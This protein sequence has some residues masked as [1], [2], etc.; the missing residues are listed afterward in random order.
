MWVCF[1]FCLLLIFRGLP[2][3]ITAVYGRQSAGVASPGARVTD[4]RSALAVEE[5][6]PSV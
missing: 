5:E 1:F 3:A 2:E 4:C 6:A